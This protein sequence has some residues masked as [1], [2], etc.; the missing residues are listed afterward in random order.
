MKKALSLILALVM[1]LSLC[2]CGSSK[3]IGS[4]HKE[5]NIAGNGYWGDWVRAEEVLEL[6]ANGKGTFQVILTHNSENISAGTVV[7]EGTVTWKKSGEYVII[8]RSGTEY[9]R[10]EKHPQ[11][12]DYYY[13]ADGNTPY[14]Q[15]ET[16][17]L[18]GNQLIDVA[19]PGNKWSKTQ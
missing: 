12:D 14:E 15:A 6:K 17:E 1:C 19:K 9:L 13:Y 16:Y 2:A 5:Y 11:Y 7:R 4:Y 3:Y 8:T 10:K 18:K